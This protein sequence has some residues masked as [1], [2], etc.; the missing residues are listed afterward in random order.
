[1]KKRW[2]SNSKVPPLFGC[3]CTEYGFMLGSCSWIFRN[4]IIRQCALH[5]SVYLWQLL[6]KSAVILLD[7][8][9]ANKELKKECQES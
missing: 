6:I 5:Y 3:D 8:G 4:Q 2:A 7:R 1:M 9:N